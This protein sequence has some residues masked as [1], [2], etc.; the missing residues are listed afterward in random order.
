MHR[1]LK[2]EA[3]IPPGS[4]LRTQQAKFDSFRDEFNTDRPHEALQ[5]AYPAE[6]YRRSS[7]EMPSRIA[8]YDYPGHFIV[9]RVSRCGTIRVFRNQIFVTQVLNE[10]DV[11]LE[12]V[13]DEYYD[14]YFC[15][16]LIG[17]YDLRRNKIHDIISKVPT[18]RRRADRPRRVSPVSLE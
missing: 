18:A 17:L 7:L 13:D 15:F 5:M 16:Y 10:E 4:S 12:E 9:R 14:L 6:V 3:T 1:T 2:Q 11:G 8:R